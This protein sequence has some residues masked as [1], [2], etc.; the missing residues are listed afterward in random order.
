ALSRSIK[1]AIQDGSLKGLH[2]S[3]NLPP[4][5]HQ[6]FADDTFLFG[7]GTVPEA[8][9]ISSILDSYSAAAGQ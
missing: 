6:Q 4:L 2:V 5:T 8:R 9:R 7:Q 3:S 1:A